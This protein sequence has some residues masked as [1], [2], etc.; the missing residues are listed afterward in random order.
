MCV[1]RETISIRD[2]QEEWI[3]ENHMSLSSFVQTK[4]DEHIEER[5]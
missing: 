3:Q 2:D 4:L 1:T 5:T